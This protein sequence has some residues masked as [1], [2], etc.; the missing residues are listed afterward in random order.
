MLARDGNEAY[1]VGE[2]DD[3][4]GGRIVVTETKR[5]DVVTQVNHAIWQYTNR[6]T[7]ERWEIPFSLRNVLPARDQRST[8]L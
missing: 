1:T 2:Y 5:Y 3:P 7:Q 6:D 8:P 4:D